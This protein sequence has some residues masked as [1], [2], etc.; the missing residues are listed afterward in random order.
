MKTKTELLLATLKERP[1][2]WIDL[3]YLAAVAG[4]FDVRT[5]ASRLRSWGYNIENKIS[6]EGRT[7]HSFY[8]LVIAPEQ[9][10]FYFN[11]PLGV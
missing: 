2:E 6:N 3:P 5:R 4:T 1:N 8:R 7:R 11:A 9:Q 10:G